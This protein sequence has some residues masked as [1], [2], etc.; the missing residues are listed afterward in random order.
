MAALLIL[1]VFCSCQR[2]QPR[3]VNA[4]APVAVAASVI[5]VAAEA[6]P[7][8][9]PVTGTL[10]SNTRV[11]VKAEVIGRVTRFEK[12]EGARVQAGEPV[13]W[14]NDENY[15][16][17]LR[18]AETAVKVAEAGVERARLLQ[19]HS[20][21]ELDRAENLLKSG[22]ITDK[23]LKAS[24]LAEQ[25]AAAQVTL[26]AAQLGQARA[27][28]D[29]AGKRVRD[30]VIHAPVSGEIQRKVVNQGAY[31]EAPTHL[32]TIVDNSR[33]ELESPVAAADL[34][35]VQPG[36]RVHFTVNSYPG[37]SFTGRVIEVNPA[38]DEQ[39]RSAKVRIEVI[40]GVGKLKAGMF[41]TGEIL[42]GLNSGA[43]V[44]PAS[45]AYRDDRSV[46]A[47]YVFVLENGKA[48]RRNV[49]IGHERDARLEISEGLRPGDQVIG[50]QNIEIAEGVRVEAR[51]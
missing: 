9:I 4:S 2:Q 21:S 39:T 3:A 49:R 27:A 5:T 41:A 12:E 20:R 13:V 34:A 29:V 50:E 37:R 38:V 19:S 46:K 15:R 33:L 25:D 28:Q 32:F 16:L 44:I 40:H 7:V 48:A 31:V 42:T 43:I 6:F 11:E 47:S 26:A 51:K 30:T 45:A 8:T 22:G 18:Q 10:V 23:D 17:Q 36:Q 24:R 35:P 14:V 1:P